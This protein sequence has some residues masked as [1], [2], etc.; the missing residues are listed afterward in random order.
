M[1]NASVRR[2]AQ[3][4]FSGDDQ[5]IAFRGDEFAEHGFRLTSLVAVGGVDE[6]AAGRQ[7]AIKNA[8]GFFALGTMAPAG[9]KVA[10]TQ[11]QF[12]NPQAGFTAENFVMHGEDS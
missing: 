2:G 4:V 3:R 9:A 1:G 12:G 8:L 6:I 11:G 5:A 10:G 7:V